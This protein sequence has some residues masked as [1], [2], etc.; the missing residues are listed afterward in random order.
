MGKEILTIEINFTAIKSYF[1]KDVDIDKILE[2]NKIS[3]DEKIY[4]Y[5]I[6]YLYNDKEVK[7]SD[8]MLP[9]TNA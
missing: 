8:I 2:S 6:G 3:S 5:F 7:L 1:L 4:M 9:K